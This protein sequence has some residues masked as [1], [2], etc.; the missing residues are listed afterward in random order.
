MATPVVTVAAGGL[1]VVDV[2]AT[3]PKLGLPVTEASNGRGV[4]VTKV[5]ANGLSV[6]F[7]AAGNE[8]PFPPNPPP[9]G[10]GGAASTE[11]AAWLARAPGLDAAHIAADA[12]MI[13]GLVAD[14]VWS[15]FDVLR[16]YATQTSAVA[17]LNMVSSSFTAILNGSPVFT[18][19]RG[20]QGVDASATVSINEVLNPT[21]GS[22]KYV[23]NSCHMGC[24]N[25][26][27]AQFAAP[28]VGMTTPSNAVSY[29][30]PRSGGLATYRIQSAPFFDTLTN[31]VA[32][33][34]YIGS[35]TGVNTVAAYKN[36]AVHPVG[37][38]NFT[39]SASSA[40]LVNLSFYSLGYNNNG[41]GVGA[42]NQLAMFCAGSGLTAAEIG[43]AYAR[44]RTRM[45]AVG[46][47]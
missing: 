36:G 9:T 45:T 1:P 29:V 3:F 26:T 22:P 27:E 21:V 18:P 10:G 15:K 38:G 23:Q 5:A 12:A 16:F 4:A 13:D 28:C 40:A 17:V 30:H 25:L 46:V 2:T 24:W 8:W 39:G 11:A 43:M 33:G 31:A 34:C 37:G 47:P 44:F 7:K 19:D 14:G 35:R 32:V 6:T 20:F 41:V 42:G